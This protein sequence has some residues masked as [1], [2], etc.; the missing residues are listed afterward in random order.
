VLSW[1]L[2]FCR[3]VRKLGLKDLFFQGNIRADKMTD[4]L[5]AEMKKCNFWLVQLGIESG[6]QRTLDGIG[7][8]ITLEQILQ[9]S[10]ILK[11]H[12]IKVYGY[13]MIYH[14]WEEDGKFCYESPE[15]VDRTLAFVRK[16]KKEKLLDY[17]S[18]S[19]TTPMRG[20]ALFDIAKRHNMLKQDKDVN[21]L[22]DFLMALPGVS[23]KAMKR[24]RRKGLLLQLWLNLFSGHN[25]LSDWSRNW[26][27]L[28]TFLK[29]M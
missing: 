27:K 2:D 4:E 18:F 26:H 10:R 1:A 11:R 24:S 13:I 12:G 19:T 3:E 22:S 23:E 20:S 15:D 9:T 6:N 14:A 25:N 29:S 17:M 8:H 16:M 21:D 7:K 5:A 28:K